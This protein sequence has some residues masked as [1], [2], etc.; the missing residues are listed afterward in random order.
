MLTTEKP[1]PSQDDVASAV[2]WTGLGL[3]L[4]YF[5]C[6]SLPKWS[7]LVTNH[8]SGSRLAP[9]QALAT[10]LMFALVYNCHSRAQVQNSLEN[11]NELL[12]SVI[13]EDQATGVAMVVMTSSVCALLK[14]SESDCRNA[15]SG[16][17]F[18]YEGLL[19]ALGW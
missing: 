12:K 3:N 2:A 7:S 14:S 9:G 8:P 13:L 6:Y 16:T 19:V 5:G 1:A 15:A 4:L 17:D 11:E 18:L 10:V